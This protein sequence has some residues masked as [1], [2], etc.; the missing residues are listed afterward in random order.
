MA[1]TSLGKS[2]TRRVLFSCTKQEQT[3]GLK[4]GAVVAYKQTGDDTDVVAPSGAAAVNL[5]GV[6]MDQQPSAG[7]TAGDF[8]NVQT[9]GIAVCLLA[10]GAT[11]TKGNLAIVADTAGTV[12]QWTNETNCDVV[13]VFNQTRT[14]GSSTDYIEVKLGFYRKT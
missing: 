7:T 12:K 8:V 1:Y 14:A 6:I 2:A 9:D 11:G 4:E 10:T 5:C 3:G 13:G